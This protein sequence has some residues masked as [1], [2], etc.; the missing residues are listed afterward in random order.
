MTSS[1]DQRQVVPDYSSKFNRTDIEQSFFSQTADHMTMCK[2]SSADDQAYK[3]ILRV[4][5]GYFRVIRER[6]AE[7]QRA[8]SIRRQAIVLGP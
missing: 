3:N 2:F 5:K 4:L 7:V 8:Q 6:E 1:A